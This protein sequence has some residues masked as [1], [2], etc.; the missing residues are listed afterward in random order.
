M[1]ESLPVNGRFTHYS[2]VLYSVLLRF[3]LFY[4]SLFVGFYFSGETH[5][6]CEVRNMRIKYVNYGKFV[7]VSLFFRF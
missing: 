5:G 4:G 1:D 3:L 2:P 6:T 7:V